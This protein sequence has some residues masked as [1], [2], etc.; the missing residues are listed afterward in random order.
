MHISIVFQYSNRLEV[1]LSKGVWLHARL[2]IK[3][4]SSPETRVSGRVEAICINKCVRRW[5]NKWAVSDVTRFL[6]RRGFSELLR[7][8]I[9]WA[10]EENRFL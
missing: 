8:G 4:E 7:R 1:P 3:L 10:D 6:H 5:S 9:W 2:K